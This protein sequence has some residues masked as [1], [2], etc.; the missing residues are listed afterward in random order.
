M[1]NEKSSKATEGE[2]VKSASKRRVA[3]AK[4]STAETATTEAKPKTNRRKA[5]AEQTQSTDGGTMQTAP[6]TPRRRPVKAAPVDPTPETAPETPAAPVGPPSAPERLSAPMVSEAPTLV[7]SNPALPR[8]NAESA[9]LVSVVLR[10]PEV[11]GRQF[12]YNHVCTG[13]EEAT[14]KYLFKRERTNDVMHAGEKVLGRTATVLEGMMSPFQARK[15]LAK[16]PEGTKLTMLAAGHKAVKL[17]K[18]NGAVQAA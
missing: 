2:T 18:F 7:T 3:A 4:A 6:K 14:G 10:R 15:L 16:Q 1:S 11:K 17:V 9:E 13:R 5:N 12:W 8:E